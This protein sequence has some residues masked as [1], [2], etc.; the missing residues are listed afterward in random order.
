MTLSIRGRKLYKKKH[1]QFHREKSKHEKKDLLENNIEEEKATNRPTLISDLHIVKNYKG[2][3]IGN[4][5]EELNTCLFKKSSTIIFDE[6]SKVIKTEEK[7]KVV[8]ESHSKKEQEV[9]KPSSQPENKT[10]PRNNKE[11][12]I[13]K[14]SETNSSK[15]KL[16]NTGTRKESS[17]KKTNLKTNSKGNKKSHQS[18]KVSGSKSRS[19]DSIKNYSIKNNSKNW[20][21]AT[22]SIL[23]NNLSLSSAP[24][25]S[26]RDG[27][28]FQVK[29]FENIKGLDSSVKVLPGIEN[30]NTF[31]PTTCDTLLTIGH[32]YIK[33]KSLL[34][35]NTL[36]LNR[37]QNDNFFK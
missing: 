28:K 32:G 26:N 36:L 16:R 23:K 3:I 6:K 19:P 12:N 7:E 13:R 21:H 11:L 17:R 35:D 8:L 9:I 10:S 4:L 27:R 1:P 34:K 37:K 31:F 18:A 24:A 25:I 2:P 22:E 30:K 29:N 20:E 5:I 15:P 33:N 14:M